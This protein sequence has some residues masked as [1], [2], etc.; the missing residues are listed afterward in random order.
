MATNLT[1]SMNL[2]VRFNTCILNYLS[3][4]ATAYEYYHSTAKQLYEYTFNEVSPYKLEYLR[5]F[6]NIYASPN[7]RWYAVITLV[8]MVP[9]IQKKEFQALYKEFVRLAKLK[10]IGNLQVLQQHCSILTNDVV[11]RHGYKEREDTPERQYTDTS[12][13]W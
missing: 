9:N 13:R 12:H 5:L 2:H 1:V 8:G 7:G 4:E 10:N 3:N 6:V 11:G